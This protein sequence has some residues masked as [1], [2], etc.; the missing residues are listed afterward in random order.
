M[1]KRADNTALCASGRSSFLA[2]DGNPDSVKSSELKA[3]PV[4]PQAGVGVIR[5]DCNQIYRILFPKP[6][7]RSW[8]LRLT[9]RD[10]DN[11][12]LEKGMRGRLCVPA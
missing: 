6:T 11:R 2:E 12:F 3:L 4:I 1:N 8:C 5:Y 10:T 7:C 9:E